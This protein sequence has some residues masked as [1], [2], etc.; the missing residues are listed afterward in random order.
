MKNRSVLLVVVPM[1]FAIGCASVVDKDKIS[2]LQDIALWKARSERIVRTAPVTCEPVYD[3]ARHQLNTYLDTTLYGEIGRIRNEFSSQIDL[4][5]ERIPAEVMTSV[6]AF[7]GCDQ[8]RVYTGKDVEIDVTILQA[9]AQW[10]EREESERRKASA[11]ALRE[12]VVK[13]KWLD[14]KDIKNN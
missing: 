5:R 13:F 6:N 1:F 2:G 14:W 3:D 10:A 8:L 11:A 12:E 7:L 9:V 4:S